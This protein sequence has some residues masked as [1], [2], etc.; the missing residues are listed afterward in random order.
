MVAGAV[1]SFLENCHTML[2]IPYWG[3]IVLT[4]IGIRACLLPVAIKTIQG[5]ARMAVMRPEMQ[6]V[7]D[8][9]TKDPNKDDQRVTLRYQNEMKALFIKHK[10]NPLRAVLWPL[11][12]FPVFIAFFMALKEMGTYY[13]GFATGGA[14]WFSNLAAADPYLILP[15]FNSLSFL[16]MVEMGADGINAQQQKTFRNVMRGL[17]V[18]MVPLTMDM[19]SVSVA[20]SWFVCLYFVAYQSVAHTRALWCFIHFRGFSCLLACLLAWYTRAYALP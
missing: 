17:A 5:S 7:Q 8:M 14:A 19:P 3:A 13:P 20:T 12:Q 18:V 4:T 2:D 1:M 10:V 15:L 16:L 11:F 9:M 6:K